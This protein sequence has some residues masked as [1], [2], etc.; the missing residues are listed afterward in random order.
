MSLIKHLEDLFHIQ[1]RNHELLQQ[2]FK[3][4]SYVNETHKD[5]LASNE[6]LEF[7]GDAVLEL[8]VSQYLYQSYPNYSEGALSRTRSQLVREESLA[9]LARVFAFNR[10]IK[11][12]QGEIKSRGYER[13]SI[14]ADCFESFLGALFLDQGLSSVEAILMQYLLIPHQEILQAINKDYKTLY[15]EIVQKAGQVKIEYR[16]LSSAGPAHQL[17]FEVGLFVD[18]HLQ[19][20]GKGMNK[21]SAEMQAAQNAIELLH[22]E[23]ASDVSK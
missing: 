15:Q 8:I 13:D 17:E 22:K 16:L 23:R 21:K 5:K 7:L 10:Y 11:L 18:N 3:H 12:G 4:T 19:A 9:R 1:I 6:R 20:T 14:L 2:A